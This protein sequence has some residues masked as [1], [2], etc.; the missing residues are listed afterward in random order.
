MTKTLHPASIHPASIYVR[1][2]LVLPF[3]LVALVAG[4]GACAGKAPSEPTESAAPDAEVVT[5]EAGQTATTVA[6]LLAGRF[7][8]LYVGAGGVRVRGASGPPLFVVDGVPRPGF[9]HDVAPSDVVGLRLL[10]QASE[11]A[12]WGSRG[13]NGV[14]LIT[15]RSNG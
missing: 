11:T 4:L 1:I 5:E 7:P 8:G 6:D 10:R 2:P 14:I 15:T 12:L 3:I 9:P 13:G